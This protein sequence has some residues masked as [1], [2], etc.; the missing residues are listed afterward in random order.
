M[1]PFGMMIV[2]QDGRISFA[3]QYE[4]QAVT[5]AFRLSWIRLDLPYHH[6][7]E[8]TLLVSCLLSKNYR[9]HRLQPS[10]IYGIVYHIVSDFF[11]HHHSTLPLKPFV[12]LGSL[13]L[14]PSAF[15]FSLADEVFDLGGDAI[16]LGSAHAHRVFRDLL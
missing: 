4:G 12:L 1:M 14:F 6:L 3:S 16:A 5:N 10:P 7:A 11:H 13:A 2:V 8:I 15:L 9:R